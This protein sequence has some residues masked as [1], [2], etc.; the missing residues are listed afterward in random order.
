MDSDL[1]S[2]V[3]IAQLIEEDLQYLKD[4]EHAEKM[5]FDSVLAVS[6]FRSGVLPKFSK[7][8]LP[9][10]T[11]SDDDATIAMEMF[12]SGARSISDH[13][14]AETLQLSQEAA[15]TA[16][17][18]LAQKIAAEENKVALDAEFARRL[19]AANDDGILDVD[20]VV[21]VER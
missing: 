18:Q 11:Q 1:A 13:S 7:K 4:A 21:D 10:G 2:E 17:K 20:A 12:L 16:G 19:Q 8:E 9:T 6:A 15:L 3:L 5:Q 14:I